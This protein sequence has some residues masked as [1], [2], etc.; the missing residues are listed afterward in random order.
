[1]TLH[2]NLE[3]YT[4]RAKNKLNKQDHTKRGNDNWNE[5]LSER[6][7]LGSDLSD[8]L[9]SRGRAREFLRNGTCQK[10][11]ISHQQATTFKRVKWLSSL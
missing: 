7:R 10:D 2:K 1:M 9:Q 3:I 5:K 11:L 6:F 4:K 8:G